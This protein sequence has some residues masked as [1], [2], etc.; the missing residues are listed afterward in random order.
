MELDYRVELFHPESL[1]YRFYPEVE[2]YYVMDGSAGVQIEGRDSVVVPKNEFFLVNIGVSHRVNG[3][4]NTVVALL[5][6]DYAQLLKMAGAARLFFHVNTL[7]DRKRSHFRLRRN[8]ARLLRAHL[9]DGRTLE[10]RSA[11]FAVMDTLVDEYATPGQQGQ[12]GKGSASMEDVI[13]YVNLHYKEKLTL[14][15]ICEKF[16]YSTSTFTR[17]FREAT[18]ENLIRYINRLRVSGAA[19]AL[20]STNLSV[21]DIALGEG[22]TDLAVF[23]KTFKKVMGFSPT[24]YR[25]QAEQNNERGELEKQTVENA[26]RQYLTENPVT[27]DLEE[28]VRQDVELSFSPEIPFQRKWTKAVGV[29]HVKDLELAECRQQLL[30]LKEAMHLEMVRLPDT[31]R[32]ISGKDMNED[33]PVFRALDGALDFLV[34]NGFS[35]FFEI[36]DRG[37]LIVEDD[38]RLEMSLPDEKKK[39]GQ[40][41]HFRKFFYHLLTRYGPDRCRNWIWEIAWDN[42]IMTAQEYGNFYHYCRELIRRWIPDAKIGGWGMYLGSDIPQDLIAALLG[43]DRPDFLS[44]RAYPYVNTGEDADKVRKLVRDTDPSFFFHRMR[45]LKE[46]MRELSVDI[47]IVISAFNLTRSDR[48][49]INDSNM[50]AALLMHHMMEMNDYVAMGIYDLASD[51]GCRPERAAVPLFGGRGLVSVDGVTK[52]MLEVLVGLGF[53]GRYLLKVGD[54]Y[55]FTSDRPNHFMGVCYNYKN[56]NLN[57]YRTEESRIRP[58]EIQQ[59]SENRDRLTLQVKF[60]G[61]VDGKYFIRKGVLHPDQDCLHKWMGMGLTEALRMED[62]AL[63]RQHIIPDVRI[64]GCPV[65]NGTAEITLDMAPNEID[66]VE[67]QYTGETV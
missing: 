66:F 60:T 14:S 2:L 5:R 43:E 3:T 51:L 40:K 50:K 61:A 47:P 38:G 12:R 24:Q 54:S 18:G 39:S 7:Q 29:A 56:F 25:R 55:I 59:Y 42:R 41:D 62:L 57:Y 4:G 26:K 31:L 8:F 1:D 33:E 36:A 30:M 37:E 67:L 9:S 44:V 27:S 34:S 65:R 10:E 35:V 48:S 64:T 13:L 6:V 16:Y 53:Q 45:E 15:G 17:N 32:S 21:S 52:P 11:F 49:Y 19:E 58:E 63:L 28:N 20:A 22:F 46:K 23:N